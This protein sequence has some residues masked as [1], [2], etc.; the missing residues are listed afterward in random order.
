MPN[1]LQKEINIDFIINFL[2]SKFRNYVYNIILIVINRVYK[3]T[4]IYIYN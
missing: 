4:L 3:N 2:L 1:N